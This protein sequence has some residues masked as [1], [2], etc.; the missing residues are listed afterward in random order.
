MH[1]VPVT[2]SVARQVIN[3][4][5]NHKGSAAVANKPHAQNPESSNAKRKQPDVAKPTPKQTHAQLMAELRQADQPLSVGG[6][7]TTKPCADSIACDAGKVCSSFASIASLGHVC[8][9]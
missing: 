9:P 1:N 8:S 2:D 4:V 5:S 3:A 6:N 7:H